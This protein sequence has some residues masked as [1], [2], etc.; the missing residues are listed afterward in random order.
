MLL[1]GIRVFVAGGDARHLVVISR[2]LERDAQVDLV[3]YDN[4]KP[5]PPGATHVPFTPE[6]LTRYDAV[7]LPVKGLGEGG[8]AE[9][10]F[11]SEAPVFTEAHLEALAGATL[12]S[13]IST[14][15]LTRAAERHGLRVVTLLDRDDVAILN[16]I[17][18]A[19]GALLLAIQNSEIT[20][21][22]ST[23]VVIGLGR[24]GMTLA[25]VLLGI[26]ARVRAVVREAR[27]YAR[28]YEMGIEP[29]Y[30]RDIGKAL[31]GAD[32][33]FNTA[34]APV[35]TA[36]VLLEL[37]PDAF[38]LDLASAPGGTDFCFAEKRGIRAML[39][40]SLPGLVAPRTAGEILADALVRLLWENHIA[41]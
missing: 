41:R 30:V 24:V 5:P 12:Y 39:A 20:L 3:G 28:A 32:F 4:L 15:F 29:Y 11:S 22:G 7:L 13:G 21:H 38:V 9:T 10:V 31:R 2:L 27:D 25:R 33:V 14:P 36:E 18:T 40:P 19:E 23:S 8:E 6:R 37:K 17:P 34:P 35:L 1:S 16:A 26:G